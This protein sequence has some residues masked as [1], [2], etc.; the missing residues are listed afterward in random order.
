MCLL[1]QA[2]GI[3]PDPDLLQ[4]WAQSHLSWTELPLGWRV[5][6]PCPHTLDLSALLHPS[7][8]T[9]ARHLF[10]SVPPYSTLELCSVLEC[11]RIQGAVQNLPRM[12]D[13][14]PPLAPASLPLS[15][16]R[17][18]WAGQQPLTAVPTS[19]VPATWKTDRRPYTGLPVQRLP[20]RPRPT[21]GQVRR[22]IQ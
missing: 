20:R 9:F 1:L 10:P 14:L 15:I 22:A 16:S 21:V 5:S 13:P 19:V 8:G 2:P 4:P 6:D 12:W 17:S 18:G 11:P 3:R 7:E